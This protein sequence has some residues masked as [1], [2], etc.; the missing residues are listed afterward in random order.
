[1]KHQRFEKILQ[2]LTE[3]EGVDATPEGIRMMKKG[4]REMILLAHSFGDKEVEAT[5]KSMIPSIP[6]PNEKSEVEDFK[7]QLKRVKL[8]EERV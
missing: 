1:M 2:I 8:T 5:L 3:Q 4:M 6:K 7:Q